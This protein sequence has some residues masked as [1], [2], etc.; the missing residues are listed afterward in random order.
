MA[1]LLVLA[2]AS[3]TLGCDPVGVWNDIADGPDEGPGDD[4]DDGDDTDAAEG[5]SGVW[6][7]VEATDVVD[8]PFSVTPIATS[9]VNA[10]LDVG[11]GGTVVAAGIERDF[12]TGMSS[13]VL[14]ESGASFARTEIA[15]GTSIQ[16]YALDVDIDAGGIVHLAYALAATPDAGG[17]LHLARKR[18]AHADDA[19]VT[20]AALEPGFAFVGVDVAGDGQ[21]RAHLLMDATGPDSARVRRY[22]APGP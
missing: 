8:S 14:L 3:M 15:S 9:L 20:E 21:G 11:A 5:D 6:S 19:A 10:A 7:A 12:E 1:R 4:G 22:L 18:G 17:V 13:V 16:P 2:V